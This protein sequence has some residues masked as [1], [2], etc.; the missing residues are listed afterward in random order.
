M[1]SIVKVVATLDFQSDI[2]G[3]DAGIIVKDLIKEI[4]PAVKKAVA[5]YISTEK[6]K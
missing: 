1:A 5:D 6:S 4:T 3:K 2:L